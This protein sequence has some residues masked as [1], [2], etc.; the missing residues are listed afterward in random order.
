[1]TVVLGVSC[2][3]A[4]SLLYLSLHADFDIYPTDVLLT[5]AP[6]LA[7][8]DFSHEFMLETDASGA[9]LGALLGQKAG[10]WVSATHCLCKPNPAAT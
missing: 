8:P 9:R 6:V 7:F 4:N 10:G 5:V 3:H 2:V 1:M